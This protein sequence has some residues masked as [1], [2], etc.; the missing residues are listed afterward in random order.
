MSKLGDLEPFIGWWA[1]ATDATPET[2]LPAEL[3]DNLHVLSGGSAASDISAAAVVAYL[4]GTE[5][6][7]VTDLQP[8]ANGILD[9]DDWMRTCAHIRDE[10]HGFTKAP[11]HVEEFLGFLPPELTEALATLQRTPAG[12]ILVDGPTYAAATLILHRLDADEAL[13]I[14]PLQ[15]GAHP[16]EPIVWDQLDLIPLLPVRTRLTNGELAATAAELLNTCIRETQT[17]LHD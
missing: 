13:R 7:E 8:D 9:F 5:P 15:S 6:P 12:A 1:D 10:R 4:T 14:R 3:D 16:L 2:M 17:P 11:N